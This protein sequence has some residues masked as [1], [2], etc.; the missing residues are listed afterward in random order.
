VNGDPGDIRT[1]E[2][3]LSRVQAR[4][5]LDSELTHVRVDRLGTPDGSCR[6][7]EGCHD[8]VAGSFDHPP[9]VLLDLTRDRIVVRCEEFP[10]SLVT[11]RGSVPGGLNKVREQDD[12]ETPVDR[13]DRDADGS[14]DESLDLVGQHTWLRRPEF[15]I[16]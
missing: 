15:E 13:S 12:G 6:S 8:P 7:V 16:E 10:P 1:Y 3:D 14:G 9:P 2:L 4:S 11:D 5:N